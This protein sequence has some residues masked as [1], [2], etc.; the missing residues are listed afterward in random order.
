MDLEPSETEFEPVRDLRPRMWPPPPVQL[1]AISDVSLHAL[2]PLEKQLDQFYCKLLQFERDKQESIAGVRIVYR[3]EN[4]RLKLILHQ[5]SPGVDYRPVMVVVRSLAELV[6][7]LIEGGIKYET[8][9]G[10]LP[11][12]NVSGCAIQR[13]ITY[14]SIRAWN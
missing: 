2:E 10:L 12:T 5:H 7:K 14:R 9:N 3:A 1:V 11:G 8:Q 6:G 13:G 4:A